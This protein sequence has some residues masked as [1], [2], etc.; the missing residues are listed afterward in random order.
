MSIAD[1]IHSSVLP[2]DS[3]L[4]NPSIT[5]EGI[6]A[7]RDCFAVHELAAQ[8]IAAAS[9]ALAAYAGQPEVTIDR[10]L[11][12]LWFA[13]SFRPLDWS[14]PKLRDEFSADYKTRDGWVRLHCN[15]KTHRRAVLS[16]LGEPKDH[17]AA[18]EI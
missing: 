3:K 16:V 4:D 2:P 8:S 17:A 13:K 11:A 10:R 6:G 14:M 1:T 12:S 15:A 5:I 9:K 7:T 18:A